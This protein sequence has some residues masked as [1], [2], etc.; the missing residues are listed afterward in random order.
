MGVK[1]GDVEAKA[2]T[3]PSDSRW[4]MVLKLLD[5]DSVSGSSALMPVYGR[6]LY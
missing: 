2:D 5:G 3:F 6:S 1:G 4:R